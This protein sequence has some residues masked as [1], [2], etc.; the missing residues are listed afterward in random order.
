MERVKRM[1]D[2]AKHKQEYL[3][4]N[5]YQANADFEELNKAYEAAY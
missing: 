5:M 2:N 4:S 1:L 3:N